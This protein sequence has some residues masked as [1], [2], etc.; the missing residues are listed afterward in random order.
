MGW[1]RRL[2]RRAPQPPPLTAELQRRI[3]RSFDEAADDEEHFPSEI[4][5][6]ILHVRL[7]LEALGDLEGKRVLD[8]GCGKGRFARILKERYP[9][10]E[11][12]GLDLSE[13]MLARVPTAIARCAGTLTALPFAS[14][15]FDGAFAVESLEHA[16]AVD[17]AVAELCRV[18][19]PGG[20]IVVIDKNI[21][22]WGRLETPPWER[23]FDRLEMERLL[24]RHCRE[25]S[26]RLI[27]YWEDV[28]PDGLFIAWMARK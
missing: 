4:D 9:S 10:A 8:A 7:I 24:R 20:A 26:S 12:W 17:A 3:R 1:L 2:F 21:E 28:P 22:Q 23:W 25:V 13:R 11:V 16:V 27:S 6:R 18:V 5:P 14:Q 15:A 19:K